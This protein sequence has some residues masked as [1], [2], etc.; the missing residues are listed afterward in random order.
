[1]LHRRLVNPTDLSATLKWKTNRI[2]NEILTAAQ[3]LMDGKA[4]E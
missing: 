1:M 2:L 3:N 4:Q